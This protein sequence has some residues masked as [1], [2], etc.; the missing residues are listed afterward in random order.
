MYPKNIKTQ[1]MLVRTNTNAESGGKVRR[2][3][4]YDCGVHVN[5]YIIEAAEMLRVNFVYNWEVK[6][7]PSPTAKHQLSFCV[8]RYEL[9]TH[10]LT[11]CCCRPVG[12]STHILTPPE[13][14]KTF[15]LREKL[16]SR[17]KDF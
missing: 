7:L 1:H 6:H 13:K 2:L 3:F 12:F 16:R 8:N 14:G 9:H 5:P 17:A 11:F 15:S 4:S 10:I